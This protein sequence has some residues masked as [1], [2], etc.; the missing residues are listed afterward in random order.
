MYPGGHSLRIQPYILLITAILS[1]VGMQA[2]WSQQ[3]VSDSLLDVIN[4]SNDETQRLHARVML[5]AE[6][7]PKEM[8]SAFKLI[9]AASPL[10]NKNAEAEKADYYNTLGVYYWYKGE[11]DSAIQAFQPITRFSESPQMLMRLARAHNNIGTLFNRLQQPDSARKYLM[12]ALRIDTERGNEPGVAKTHYDLSVMYYR[13]GKFELALRYQLESMKINEGLNDTMR[14]IHGYNVLGNIYSS[15]HKSDKALENY[16][17]A[18]ELDSVYEP[19]SMAA[20]LYNNI[21]ALLCDNSEEFNNAIAYAQK[22]L[23]EAID[24]ND[25]SLISILHC[26]IA[27]AYLAVE[28]PEKGLPELY[29]AL[30]YSLK[31][32]S[33]RQLDGLYLTFARTHLML[34]NLDSAQYYANK[35]LEISENTREIKR[36]H[37]ILNLLY[38]VDSTAGN[39]KSSLDYYKKA[40]ALKDSLWNVENRNRI[41]ELEIIYETE[42]KETAN[43]L[44]YE[45][46][47][48]SK[49]VIGNQQ[50]LIILS[51]SILVLTIIILFRERLIRR[52]ILNKNEEIVKQKDEINKQNSKL[53]ELNST[54]DKFF[55]IV[56]HD[57]R[58]PFSALVNLLQI[59]E[60]EYDQLNDDE[61]REIIHSLHE[62]ST[63]TFNLLINLLDWS[64]TQTGMIENKPVRIELHAATQKVFDLLESRAKQKKLNLINEIPDFVFAYAD[65]HFLQSILINLINNAIKYSMPDNIIRVTVAQKQNYVEICVIDN[66]IGIPESKIKDLFRIDSNFKQPGTHQEPGTGLGLI[67]VHEFMQLIGGT[68]SVKSEAGKGSTFSITLPVK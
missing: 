42:K 12:E 9:V 3:K 43:Q 22:G 6:L 4:S 54:K 24:Q 61:K 48:L 18:I 45:Q 30:S 14:M 33:P 26:N 58:G 53:L 60:E 66:G 27:A 46:N 38:L 39:Y 20:Q 28:Q 65:P 19:S 47:K 37:Q 52:K 21:A 29:T 7:I 41:S 8:D 11:F 36:Q 13:L 67:M 62:S 63:N 5:A 23:E 35:S 68:V 64:R 17:K 50:L 40:T 59:L 57:L 1:F 15:L 56:S 10:K 55:S 34:G 44:L 32:K 49:K 16:L 25:N 31:E 51:I 2:V